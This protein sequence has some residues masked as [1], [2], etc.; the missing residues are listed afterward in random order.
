LD[1]TNPLNA[2]EMNRYIDEVSN[3]IRLKRLDKNEFSGKKGVL[4][5]GKILREWKI[6]NLM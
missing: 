4:P 5:L 2:K 1:P 3:T 6:K